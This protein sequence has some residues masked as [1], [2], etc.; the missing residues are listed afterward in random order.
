L[1]NTQ[2]CGLCHNKSEPESFA[3]QPG[4]DE[5]INHPIA[6]T[7]N[8]Q[9]ASPSIQYVSAINKQSFTSA[10]I[11]FSTIRSN[12]SSGMT[13]W[14]QS[15]AVKVQASSTQK[16]SHHA[17]ALFACEPITSTKQ[18]SSAKT[19]LKDATVGQVKQYTQ[20]FIL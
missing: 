10:H 13:S 2:T 3:D 4:I 8:F 14:D 18:I 20:R 7:N 12:L 16:N 6:V 15:L 5:E 17:F 9:Q 19:A 11:P 1:T